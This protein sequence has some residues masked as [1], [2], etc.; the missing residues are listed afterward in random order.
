M[1]ASAAGRRWTRAVVDGIVATRRRLIVD[2][3][4]SAASAPTAYVL[5]LRMGADGRNL[6]GL[7][8][9]TQVCDGGGPF[10]AVP[11]QLLDGGCSK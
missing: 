11:Q 1:P 8:V 6:R 7:G 5:Q 3:D 10:V 9:Y 4:A 2:W